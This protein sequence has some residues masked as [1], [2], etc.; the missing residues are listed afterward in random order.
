MKASL[1]YRIVAVLLLLFAVGHTVGFQQSDPSWGVDALLGLM[2]SSRFDVQGFS[3]SYWDLFL[4]AGFSVGAFY[5]FSAV[6]AWQLAR[7]HAETLATMRVGVW[8]FALC[9]AV[10]TLLSVRYLFV[11][12]IV[13]AVVITACLSAG[14]WLSGRKG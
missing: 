9:F 14:A 2:R 4:A 1:I 5:V 10:I 7:L 11:I 13:F 8:A 6:L 3:R 12:P